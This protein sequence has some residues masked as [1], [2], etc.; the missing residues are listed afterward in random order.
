VT[1]CLDPNDQLDPKQPSG[2]ENGDP[3]EGEVLD[4]E[5]MQPAEGRDVRDQRILDLEEQVKRVSAEFENFRRRLQDEQKRRQVLMKE[6]LFRELLPIID[7]LD[8]SLEAGRKTDSLEALLKGVELTRRDFSKLCS[9]HDVEQIVTDGAQFDPGLHQAV[10]TEDRD[11]VADQSI[12]AEFQKGYKMGER[13]LRPSL[14]KV[15]R[16]G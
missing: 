12:V 6:E 5:P 13:L 1:Q 11:D 3:L 8:R 4:D 15:A 7:N 9:D 16:K 2:A 10:M 14:V